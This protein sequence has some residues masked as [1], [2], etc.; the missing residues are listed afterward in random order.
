MSFENHAGGADNRGSGCGCFLKVIAAALAVWLVVAAVQGVQTSR[1][2]QKGV[3]LILS[4]QYE[5]A[6]EALSP[7]RERNYRDTKG[8][9]LLCEAHR[10]YENGLAVRAYS[11]L[12]LAE[13]R[14]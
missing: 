1:A 4:G 11:T 9:L 13:F 5:Q 6:A 2:Y 12:A 10:D 7:I 8:L 3:S 14:F